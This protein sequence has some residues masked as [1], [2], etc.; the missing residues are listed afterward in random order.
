MARRRPVNASVQINVVG[1][2]KLELHRFF[3]L[4]KQG[5]AKRNPATLA[6][7]E[8]P[9][10]YERHLAAILNRNFLVGLHHVPP[11]ERLLPIVTS[12][13]REKEPVVRMYSASS[14]T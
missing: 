2:Y 9:L 8:S 12:S 1:S 4:Q 10:S 3:V 6:R 11:V 5:P 13:P 7:S 14:K